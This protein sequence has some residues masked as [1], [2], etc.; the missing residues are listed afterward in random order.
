[1]GVQDLVKANLIVPRSMLPQVITDLTEFDTFHVGEKKEI[2]P[3][4]P[5]IDSLSLQAYRLFLDIDDILKILNVQSE[6]GLIETLTKGVK[7]EKERFKASDWADFISRIEAEGKPLVE[8]FKAVL[9]ERNELQKKVSDN[10]ALKETFGLLPH[11]SVDLNV[12]RRLRRF[13]IILS[14]VSAKD[15][16]ELSLS[17]P[18]D[19]FLSTPID[20]ERNAIVVAT[21]KEGAERVDK[22]LRSF[23]VRP[24]EIPE[25]LPQSPAEALKVINQELDGQNLRLQEL[26]QMLDANLKRSE[27]KLISI[28]EGAKTAYD[29]LTEVKKAGDLK[30][31]AVITGFYPT[32]HD[33]EFKQK[34][35]RWLLFTEKVEP[36]GHHH[37]AEAEEI[38]E[39]HPAVPTLIKNRP[40]IKSF[41]NITLNQG[42]PKYGEVDP[43]PLI[44]LTFPIFYGIMFGD[45]GH[46]VV[47]ALFG[48]LLYIRGSSSTKPWGIML[49]VAGAAAGVVGLLIG[50]VFGFSVGTIIPV[51]QTPVLELVERLHGTTNFN[52]EAVITILQV[53]IIIG[54]IHLTIGFGLDVFKAMRDKEYVE[55]VTEK[56]PTLLMYLFGIIFALAFIG[57]GNSFAG[58]LTKT[59]PIPLLGLP[60]TQATIISLPVI[61]ASVVTIIIGKPV[62]IILHKAPKDSIAMSAVMGVVEFLI[63]VVEFLANTMSYTR[64]GILLLVHAALLMVLN[65]AVSLPLPVA[66]PMLVIFNI[67][68]MMLEGL[69]VYIQDLRLHLYEWF[70]KFYAGTGTLFRRLKPHPVH[71]DIEWEKKE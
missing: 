46:G 29:V 55:A 59:N 13:H 35:S 30:R 64:L 17:L 9:N 49:I 61:L 67:M 8:E 44:M 36:V 40:L 3:S 14:I 24:L 21:S 11:L 28:R 58:M 20:S 38:G 53:S 31:F 6:V 42:P 4:D 70:T 63:R 1:M 66:V 62:A 2:T 56:I 33:A 54:I 5:Q 37:G 19:I 34:F 23:E 51:Y 57:A 52:T 48:L 18:E 25:R 41:E 60:V 7:I 50:E 26:N 68:I 10:V 12:I 39:A 65:R 69:I 43:T 27:R 16:Q 15:V 47:L 71:L 22:T 32:T 45:F